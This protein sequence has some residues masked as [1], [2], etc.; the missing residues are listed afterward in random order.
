[1]ILGLT[2]DEVYIPGD[3]AVSVPTYTLQRD[4]RYFEK[5]LEFI[6]E[7][8]TEETA[9]MVKDKRAFIPFSTGIFGCVGK[10]LALMELRMV[11]AR[12]ALNFDVQFAEGEDGRGLEEESKDTFTLTVPSMY[13]KL[14]ERAR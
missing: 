5:A 7:R 2:I 4:E 6:P 3:V 10:N 9:H 14:T 12:V 13:V 8:W 11:L 1:L